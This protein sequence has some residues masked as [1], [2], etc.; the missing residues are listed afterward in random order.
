[1]IP[2]RPCEDPHFVPLKIGADSA[3]GADSRCVSAQVGTAAP[4]LVA[5]VQEGGKE[6]TLSALYGGQG[7]DAAGANPLYEAIGDVRH[8]PDHRHP[9]P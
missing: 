6:A 2:G 4:M 8:R 5:L 3:G 7:D 1:M 9:K